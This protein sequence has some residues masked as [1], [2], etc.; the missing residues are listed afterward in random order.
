MATSETRRA[1][2]AGLTGMNAL[3]LLLLWGAQCFVAER[4]WLT[5]LVTY[6]PQWPFCL[7][8]VFLLLAARFAR[9]TWLFLV[10]VAALTFCLVTLLGFRGALPSPL[11]AGSSV[12][13]LS[14]NIEHGAAG[15][16]K[17]AAVIRT[18]N[19]DVIC[20]QETNG[21]KTLPDPVPALRRALAGFHVAHHG[22]LLVASRWPIVSWKARPLGITG[23]RRP[24][25]EAVLER[26][27]Q[28]LTVINVHLATSLTGASLANRRDT[29]PA[30]LEQTGKV[31]AAQVDGLLRWTRQINTP[32]VVAGDFNTP[33]RGRVYRRLA[34]RMDDAWGQRGRGLGYTYPSHRPQMRIDYVFVANGAT[35]RQAVVP[36][37]RASD[38]RPL[39]VDVSLTFAHKR[40]AP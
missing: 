23:A 32:L 7:P 8:T 34:Q 16:D 1:W 18:T 22:E 21:F 14:F 3:A 30:Y 27:E 39:I 19:A 36:P 24:V 17:I 35:P 10:N 31:R 37:V 4:H 12:R 20:L 33:P 11:K 13:V 25:L 29:L 9:R 28:R 5:T 26:E 6:V 2:L 15:V 38:H 40:T